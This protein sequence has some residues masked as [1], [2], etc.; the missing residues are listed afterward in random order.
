MDRVLGKNPSL[1]AA[2]DAALADAYEDARG[3]AS[4]ETDMSLTRFPERCPYTRDDFMGRQIEWL[5]D[6]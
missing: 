4:S 6:R 1:K 3:E 5:A 2:F